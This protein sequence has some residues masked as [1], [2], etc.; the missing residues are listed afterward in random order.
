MN[1]YAR[2]MVLGIKDFEDT[3]GATI[4]WAA[5]DYPCAGGAVLGGKLLGQG[6]FRTT[7]QIQIA[8]RTCLF[9]DGAG[10]PSEKQTL[11]YKATPEATARAL[12]IDNTTLLWDDVLLLDCNDPNEGT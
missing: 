8:V 3:I 7:S 9:P 5:T 4:N 2:A 6:G 10:R 1:D 11:T 12:R